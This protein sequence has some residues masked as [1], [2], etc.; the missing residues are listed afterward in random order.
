MDANG[1]TWTECVN[2]F[3]KGSQSNFQRYLM[4]PIANLIK[5]D[6]PITDEELDLELDKFNFKEHFMPRQV[7]MPTLAALRATQNIKLPKNTIV[8][9]STL[10]GSSQIKGEVWQNFQDK[11]SRASPRACAT[12]TAS[13]VCTTISRTL[14]I[15]GPSFMITQAC[16]GFITALDLAQKFLDSGSTD[17]VLVVSVDSTQPLNGYIFKSM[18][19][20]TQELV[21]PFD[22]NRSGMALGEGAACYVVTKESK[23]QQQVARIEKISLYNDFYNLIAPHPD[24]LAGN[25]LLTEL[26]AYEKEIGSINAH[27]TGTKVG[28][29]IELASIERLPYKTNVFGLKGSVGHTLSTSAAVEMAYSIAGLQQGWIP[30]TSNLENPLPSK[31]HIVKDQI[32]QSTTDNF[33]KL[34]FGFGGVSAGILVE[35]I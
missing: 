5:F 24:G 27:A 31:H 20:Y 21:R 17:V 26:G 29:D 35:K 16:S 28:D 14:G 19:V 2:N 8:I 9:G 30:Y 13:T 1:T 22:V 34:S 32:F 4:E 3:K 18:S 12:G 10:E 25:H 7:K 15:E 33:I 6:V 23:A 11:K